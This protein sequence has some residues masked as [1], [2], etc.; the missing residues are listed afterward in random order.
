M[1][2]FP[3]SVKAFGA[4]RVTGDYILPADVNDLRAEVVA[5][6]TALLGG[7]L[8]QSETW[9]FAS[10]S[11]FTVSGDRTGYYTKGRRL[12]WV[13][14][15]TTKYGI[16]ASSSYGAPNTT[17]NILVNTDYV[18]TAVAITAPAVSD[19]TDPQG[20]PGW[21]TWAPSWG[22]TGAMTYTGVTAQAARFCVNGR[23]VYFALRGTG[24]TGGVAS[25]AVT[26]SMPVTPVA[27]TGASLPVVCAVT[28]GSAVA[29]RGTLDTSTGSLGIAK[30]DGTN[31]GLGA[32]RV[33]YAEGFYEW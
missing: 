16:V 7:W 9:T 5:V 6:E 12:R 4:D 24:T 19:L 15:G 29:G 11:A 20:W 25:L 14:S 28:D 26:A 32:G 2:S 18:V 23:L 21:F 17:V 27:L 31:Y 13:Q 3:G 22:A 1:A 30:V 10:A 8:A 33:V